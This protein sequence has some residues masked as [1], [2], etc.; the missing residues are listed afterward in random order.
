MTKLMPFIKPVGLSVTTGQATKPSDFVYTLALRC[1]NAP[2][3][4]VDHGQIWSLYDDIIDP[5][6]DATNTFYYVEYLNY[7][8]LF[9]NDVAS[10]SLDYVCEPLTVS[11]A[12]T[13][14]SNN[15]QVYNP[16]GSVQPQWDDVS[17]REITERMLKTIGVAFKDRDFAQFGQSVQN[18]GE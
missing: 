8:L 5:P 15:R 6:S 18:A 14:D 13:F 3:F 9:P 17:C 7:Y 1:N 2:V 10:V 11:W 12:Y 4:Q 16:A